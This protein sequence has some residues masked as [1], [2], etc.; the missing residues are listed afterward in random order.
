MSDIYCGAQQVVG[1]FL[2]N[3][4]PIGAPS[5]NPCFLFDLMRYLRFNH[6]VAYVR[7]P[8]LH[9]IPDWQAFS[10]LLNHPYWERTWI[11]QEVVLAKSLVFVYG[12]AVFSWEQYCY[13]VHGLYEAMMTNRVPNME[14]ILN[15]IPYLHKSVV[16]MSDRVDTL[17]ELKRG[18]ESS[19]KS[20]WPTLGQ[21]ADRLHKVMSKDPRDQ[22]YAL[23]SL[24]C[25]GNAPELKPDYAPSVT[26]ADVMRMVLIHSF[27]YGP[28]AFS[29]ARRLVV[30]I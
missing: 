19:D 24:A 13:G 4:F 18:F 9:R 27:K 30:Q 3:E 12:E 20:Q 22:I 29:F 23:L 2:T 17:S 15:Y 5:L 11:V 1:C 6:E 14:S 10:N 28:T 8:F 21:V 7:L 16:G 26:Y 25:D